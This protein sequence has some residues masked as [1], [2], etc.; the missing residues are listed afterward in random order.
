MC[1]IA[2]P[3][4][5][6]GGR[7][8]PLRR[9]TRE[10]KGPRAVGQAGYGRVPIEHDPAVDRLE[11]VLG[12]EPRQQRVVCKAPD[13]ARRAGIKLASNAETPSTAATPASVVKSQACTPKSRLRIRVAAATE[14]PSP[15][16]IPRPVTHPASFRI[17]RWIAPRCALSAMRTPISRVLWLT[18]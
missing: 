11:T 7:E 3:G 4:E 9:R 8:R 10:R 12:D 5:R 17:S 18:E 16:I 14:Q 6:V 1:D 2:R 15:V 13:E